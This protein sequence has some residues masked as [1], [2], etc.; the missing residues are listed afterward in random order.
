MDTFSSHTEEDGFVRGSHHF[1]FGFGS[2]WYEVLLVSAGAT[3]ALLTVIL[4]GFQ[5]NNHLRHWRHPDLQKCYLRIAMIAPVYA[6]FSWLSIAKSTDAA[7]Y[8]IFRATYE[9]YALWTFFAMMLYAAGG[10]NKFHELYNNNSN[11][12]SI[13][14]NPI[15]TTTTST[16]TTTTTT[17]SL[18]QATQKGQSPSQ[19]PSPSATP[20]TLSA[21]LS[22]AA[23]TTMSFNSAAAATP[24]A[25]TIANIDNIDDYMYNNDDDDD[26]NIEEHDK[27]NRVRCYF[28][29]PACCGCGR[30]FDFGSSTSALLCWKLCLVQFLIVKPLLSA[31]TAWSERHD[32]AVTTD[33]FIKPLALCSVTLAM[34]ALLSTYLALAPVS[35]LFR[36]LHLPAKFI[37]I[38]CAI[39][40]TVAQEL[41]FHILVAS[42]SISSPYCWW[43]GPSERCLDIMGFRTP[44]AQ[45]GTRT[46]ASLVILE[47]FL[48]QFLL[49]RYYSFADEILGDIV[50]KPEILPNVVDF[51]LQPSWRIQ[52]T[53]NLDSS[54]IAHKYERVKTNDTESM[55]HD[56]V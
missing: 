26:N 7:N 15:D 24:Q 4:Y 2:S 14:N 18:N 35:A 13:N 5:L 43:A 11:S 29:P 48:L 16:T 44:S 40:L 41:C 27:I 34:F 47:M 10:E 25:I 32:S 38:K 36:K 9:G 31:V 28:F 46:I 8:D 45:R 37:V 3:L 53:T 12:N 50:H 52:P 20:P 55:P 19:S 39:F 23:T 30:A 22:A 33:R 42:G 54:A 1:G 17:N 51:F 6:L 56:S 21:A 49:L